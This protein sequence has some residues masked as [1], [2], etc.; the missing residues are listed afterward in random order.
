M[1]TADTPRL[2]AHEALTDS[3]RQLIEQLV[4]TGAPVETLASLQQQVEAMTAQLA[5]C[6]R[7]RPIGHFNNH[8]A[9]SDTRHTLPYSPVS[10]PCNPIAPPLQPVYDANT[11]TLAATV[12]CNRAYE[13]PRGLVHGAVIAGIYDQLLALLTTCSGK[14]SHTAWLTIQY[15]QPTPLHETL[16]FRAWIDRQQ[17]RKTWIKGECLFNGNTLTE[18]E[19]LFI[20][21]RP[22]DEKPA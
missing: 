9:T 15:S 18:A 5:D 12:N 6:T 14:P 11:V 3:L 16:H 19:G 7:R 10:G 1:N 22:T 13:G 2:L 20:Q 8:L 4:S 17:G 21:P